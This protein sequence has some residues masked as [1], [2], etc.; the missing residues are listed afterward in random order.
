[1][2]AG[3]PKPVTPELATLF[4]ATP[5]ASFIT[6]AFILSSFP[7]YLLLASFIYAYI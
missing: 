1:M 3:K 7:S 2:S 4:C 5:S 6:L